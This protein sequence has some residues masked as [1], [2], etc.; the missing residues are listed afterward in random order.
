MIDDES[1]KPSLEIEPRLLPVLE[2]LRVRE[3]IF[4]RPEFGTSQ[5]D[6]EAQM[7]SDFWEVGASGNRYSRAFVLAT[8]KER[9]SKPHEDP[10]ETSDFHCRELGPS[11]YALTYT[12]QQGPRMTRRL[13]LWRND[14][15]SWKI[16][17]HQGTV[18]AT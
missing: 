18:V 7:A 11:T 16:L 4:H 17:F 13:T 6:F 2:A 3:P 1:T 12:L 14:G 9:F 15:G 8:L 10:W 5:A